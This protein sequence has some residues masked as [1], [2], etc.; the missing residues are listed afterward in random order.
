MP[1]AGCP[2]WMDGQQR[3]PLPVALAL[4][5]HQLEQQLQHGVPA[6][7]LL[8]ASARLKTGWKG[9]GGCR[10]CWHLASA[11]AGDASAG[12]PRPRMAVQG[13]PGYGGYGV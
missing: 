3:A 11:I 13:R 6:A 4:R 1:G 10:T 9:E 12:R 2:A 7:Q 8:A 5:F